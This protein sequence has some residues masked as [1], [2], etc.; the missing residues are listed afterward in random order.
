PG[1]AT[2]RYSYD[3][4]LERMNGDANGSQGEADHVASSGGGGASGGY[5]VVKRVPTYE[6][7]CERLALR[8]PDAARATIEGGAR[9]LVQKVVPIFLPREAALIK[10]V[11]RDLPGDY[12]GRF[13][14]LIDI[15]TDARGLVQRLRMRWLRMGGDTMSQ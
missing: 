9:K 6:D 14:S 13:P 7:A 3:V 15:D 10:I 11:N 4:R 8:F 5:V 2:D 12:A 1:V